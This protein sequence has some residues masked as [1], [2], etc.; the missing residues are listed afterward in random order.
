MENS[1]LPHDHGRSAGE[2][3][4]HCPS[5]GDFQNISDLLRQLGD[6]TRVKLF[7]ILCHCEECVINL[8]A[9]MNMSSPALSHHLKQLRLAG[10]ILSRRDGKEVYYRAANNIQAELFHHLIEQMLEITCPHTHD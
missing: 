8:S 10:L 2:V 1:K 5:A 9:M 3:M 4:E 6:S 7:W